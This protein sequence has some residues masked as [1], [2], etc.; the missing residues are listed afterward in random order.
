MALIDKE[1]LKQFKHKASDIVGKTMDQHINLAVTGLSRSGKTAF[2][3]SF[4]NQLLNSGYSAQLSFF[5][6]VTNGQLIGAKR[7][8]Q[9]D[10]HIPRFEYDKAISAFSTTPPRWPEPTKGISQ[11]R[12]A[13]RYKPSSSLIK[14]ATDTVTLTIDITD[15]PGEWLLDLPMLNQTYEEWS[16]YTTKLLSTGIRKEKS[17]SFL[18]KVASIS[19][20]NNTDE[21][22]LADLAQEYTALLHHFK[23]ELGLSVIQPGRFVLPGDMAGAPLLQFIPFT[24]FSGLDKNEYQNATDDTLIGMLRARFN[25]YKQRV[26]KKFY[27]DHFVNFDRQVI[28][29]DCLTPLNEGSESFQEL[30]LAI[31]MIMESFDYGQSSLFSRLFSPKIDKLLFAATKSD[32]V[33][34]EQHKP[35]VSLLNQLVYRKMQQLNFENVEMKSMAISSVVVT[36]VGQGS[37][38]GEKIPL[39]QG[40]REK[41]NKL[42]TV[43]P[44]GVPP[45]LPG[46]SYWEENSF[47]FTSFVPKKSVDSHQA[48]PHLRIDQ[49]LQFLLGDKIR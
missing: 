48:L 45:R 17:K 41:D 49:A 1:K 5:E 32:H 24:A 29:A 27:K 4:I 36:D 7:V 9:K 22:L 14:L 40:I 10:F 18:E 47:H 38:N 15:Y 2:I 39:L 19:P 11:V 44:G 25:E 46:Q 37:H 28:L 13:L 26:V 16:E 31:D 35:L 42:I 34:P 3:T 30:Q 6:P 43:F 12:L 21:E 8:P 33:T 23:D 20:Y